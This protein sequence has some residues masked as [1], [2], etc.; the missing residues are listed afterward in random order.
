[1][2]QKR[3]INITELG[4][5]FSETL[6]NALLGLH[7]FSGCDTVSAFKG[8]GKV[9]PMKLVL[10]NPEYSQILSQLGEQ[11]DVSEELLTGLQKFVCAIY[12]GK[13]SKITNVDELQ[14]F[15]IKSKCDESVTGT[16]IRNIDLSTLPPSNAC[17]EQHIRRANYQTWIWKLA[18]IANY[19]LPNAWD[20]HGWCKNGE[21]YWCH[22]DDILPPVLADKLECNDMEQVN[23]DEEIDLL[24]EELE[25]DI[26]EEDEEDDEDDNEL[27][28]D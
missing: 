11:W 5:H 24:L 19:A 2:K 15:L 28:F 26:V 1:M 17:L 13:K 23:T 6:C 22:D 12:G 4:S 25:D 21:P 10:K 3:L 27:F 14:H 16:N 9:K 7:S 18:N 20:G 8:K